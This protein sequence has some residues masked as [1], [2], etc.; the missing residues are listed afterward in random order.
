MTDLDGPEY[1][2]ILPKLYYIGQFRVNFNLKRFTLAQ[3]QGIFDAAIIFFLAFQ[4]PFYKSMILDPAS[5]Q[6]VDMW[7]CSVTAFTALIFVVN[8][9]LFTRMSYITNLHGLTIFVA[10]ILPYL[11]Y[12]WIS[13]ILPGQYSK[14]ESAV[15]KAHQS[16]GFYLTTL[17]ITAITFLT[18]Y[19]IHCV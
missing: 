15:L 9:N 2:Q 16:P 10:S 18:D 8:F 12:M 3:A 4:P 17:L 19:A 5:G 14:T 1:E 6:S 11:L 13:N 7:T